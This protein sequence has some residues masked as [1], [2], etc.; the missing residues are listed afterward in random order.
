MFGLG[1]SMGH[2]NDDKFRYTTKR[3]LWQNYPRSCD[4]KAPTTISH[5]ENICHNVLRFTAADHYLHVASGIFCT[6]P[7]LV[8][9]QSFV[10]C[11]TNFIL[12]LFTIDC[13]IDHC[14]FV[15]N[16]IWEVGNVAYGSRKSS[17]TVTIWTTQVN[18]IYFYTICKST[19]PVVWYV[20]KTYLFICILFVFL[21]FDRVI[22]LILLEF[23]N[24]FLSLFYIAF[25]LGGKFLRKVLSFCLKFNF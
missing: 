3:L 17:N 22:K 20:R 8:G 4:W 24:N 23:V 15:F 19:T 6:Y 16:S 14:Y 12:A 21:F 13:W 11:W 18:K 9:G 7:I 1:I 10:R 5:V 25:W 2:N